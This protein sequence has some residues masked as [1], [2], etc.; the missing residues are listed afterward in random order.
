MGVETLTAYGARES[1]G[2]VTNC[3]E[4]TCSIAFF[5]AAHRQRECWQ[6]HGMTESGF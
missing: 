6:G 3:L 5:G 1:S 4:L 2:G